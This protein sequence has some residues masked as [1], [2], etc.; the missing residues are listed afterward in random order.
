MVT[1]KFFLSVL[2]V[3]LCGL[4]ARRRCAA[5]HLHVGNSCGF[6]VPFRLLTMDIFT[7]VVA[8]MYVSK[9]T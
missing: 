7:F 9:T 4:R 3:G 5:F 8:D 2:F 6:L 1:G